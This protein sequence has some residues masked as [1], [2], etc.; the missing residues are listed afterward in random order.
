MTEADKALPLIANLLEGKRVLDLGCGE[1]KVVPWAV[2]VDDCS[3]HTTLKPDVTAKIGYPDRVAFLAKMKSLG[4]PG[5]AGW[6]CVFSSHSLEHL[7]E[8]IGETLW[9]WFSL[10]K[11][12][13]NLILFVPDETRYVY[14]PKIPQARNPAHKHLLVST[15]VAWHLLQVTGARIAK[16]Q[17]VDYSTLFVVEKTS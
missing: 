8:P 7:R 17:D 3:E 11:P 4:L 9:W 1:K 13:G 10:V 14:D 5:E 16:K 12:E 2:G 15:V 6:D